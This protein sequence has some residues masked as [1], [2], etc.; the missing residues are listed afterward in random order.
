MNSVHERIPTPWRLLAAGAV[1]L[2]LATCG[3]LSLVWILTH[4]D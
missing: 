2:T 3:L 1:L 4:S